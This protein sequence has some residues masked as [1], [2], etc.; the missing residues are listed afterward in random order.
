MPVIINMEQARKEVDDAAMAY[1]AIYE[2]WKDDDEQLK[3]AA[4][5]YENARVAFAEYEHLAP[6]GRALD[7]RD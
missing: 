5:R 1:N 7:P 2:K 6:T 4:Q 3:N